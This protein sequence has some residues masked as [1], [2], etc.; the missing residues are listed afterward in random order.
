MAKIKNMSVK[1]ALSHKAEE[2]LSKRMTEVLESY[3]DDFK[4]TPGHEKIMALTVNNIEYFPTPYDDGDTES[5]LD[6]GPRGKKKSDAT[7]ELID[8]EEAKKLPKDKKAKGDI[9]FVRA[10]DLKVG[11]TY[12]LNGKVLKSG[13]HFGITRFVV[14]GE[15][16]GNVLADDIDGKSFGHT[17]ASSEFTIPKDMKLPATAVSRSGLKEDNT[18]QINDLQKQILDKKTEITQLQANMLNLKDADKADKQAQSKKSKGAA[19]KPLKSEPLSVEP[20][21]AQIFYIQGKK[22]GF[23]YDMTSSREEANRI[24]ADANKSDDLI[25]YFGSI[26]ESTA[27]GSYNGYT[28]WET[29]NVNLWLDNE[30]PLYK[31]KIRFIRQTPILNAQKVKDY[32]MKVFPK[33]TP[34]MKGSPSDMNN[35]NWDELADLWRD[36]SDEVKGV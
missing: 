3:L 36:E 11:K 28:N 9:S 24:M 8:A 18:E 31:D 1:E 27:R 7:A 13:D 4:G 33:G 32:C 12:E 25:E 35:V 14:K 22:S 26:S 21:G 15:R 2:L 23:N 20:G 29:W 5:D 10:G 16:N 34:D 19:P 17:P 30:E 6:K